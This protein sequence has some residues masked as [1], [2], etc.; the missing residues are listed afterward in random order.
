[1][2]ATECVSRKIH[3][4]CLGGA[5]DLAHFLAI[6]GQQ[7]KGAGLPC[8]QHQLGVNSQVLPTTPASPPSPLG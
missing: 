3:G 1:M 2:S 4:A 6:L 8:V 5:L 7:G